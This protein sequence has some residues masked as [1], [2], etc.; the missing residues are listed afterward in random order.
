MI[1]KLG[2]DFTEFHVAIRNSANMNAITIEE[3]VV[4]SMTRQFIRDTL[5]QKIS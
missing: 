5:I 2:Y 1:G 4:T 3:K